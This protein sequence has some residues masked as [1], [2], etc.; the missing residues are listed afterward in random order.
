MTS[1]KRV[2]GAGGVY[3]RYGSGTE[4]QA[5]RVGNNKR[6]NSTFDIGAQH[7]AGINITFY[8]WLQYY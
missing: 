4:K 1:G 3:G 6:S 5:S 8:L 2:L 7:T